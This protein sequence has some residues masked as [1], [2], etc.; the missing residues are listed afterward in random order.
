[1]QLTITEQQVNF[2]YY[3]ER[4]MFFTLG[5]NNDSIQLLD[6]I[7]CRTCS[8]V[9]MLNNSALLIPLCRHGR[10]YNEPYY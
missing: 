9:E 2:Y 4:E 7:H 8:T 6:Y 10:V 1:M 5:Y 3:C